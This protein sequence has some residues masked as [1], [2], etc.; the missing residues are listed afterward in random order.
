MNP[1]LLPKEMF[2]GS[3]TGKWQSVARRG[4][5]MA[6]RRQLAGFFGFLALRALALTAFRG[7]AGRMTVGRPGGRRPLPDRA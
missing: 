1:L 7:A 6:R 4:L 5:E 2:I 3:A